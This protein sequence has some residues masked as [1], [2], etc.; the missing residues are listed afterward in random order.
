MSAFDAKRIA[1]LAELDEDAC[2]AVAAELES[3]ELEAGAELFAEGAPGDGLYLLASGG[4][5]VS[6][7]RAG[8]SFE[9][10]AGAALGALALVAGG[11]REVRA[12]TTSRSRLLLLRR[13]AF[14]RIA[15]EHP[16]AACR[17]LEAILRDAVRAGREALGAGV[18]RAA[19]A[20]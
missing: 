7:A 3:V 1:L 20:D 13:S 12:E 4:L 6:S 17:L 11:P 10:G 9:I 18:D 14:R 8:A 16:H 19:S 15:A 5:R 2:D